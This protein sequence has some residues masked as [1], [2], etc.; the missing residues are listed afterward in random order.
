MF[1]LFDFTCPYIFA[2]SAESATWCSRNRTEML[3]M[4]FWTFGS[5]VKRYFCCRL[6]R[7]V[8]NEPRLGGIAWLFEHTMM[9]K[10]VAVSDGLDN[11]W[12]WKFL[13]LSEI[14]ELFNGLR[15]FYKSWLVVPI[16]IEDFGV[17][18]GLWKWMSQSFCRVLEGKFHYEA[19]LR[20]SSSCFLEVI[21]TAFFIGCPMLRCWNFF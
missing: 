5:V 17:V 2:M 16:W 6:G 13:H 7:S 14:Q 11:F 20:P 4:S 10:K 8:E 19:T 1:S 18:S 9:T 3:K 15:I 12:C 21:I